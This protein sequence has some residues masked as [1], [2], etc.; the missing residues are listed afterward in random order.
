MTYRYATEIVRLLFEFPEK[1]RFY[2]FKKQQKKNAL[3]DMFNF[4]YI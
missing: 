2:L 1:K 3:N 4:R